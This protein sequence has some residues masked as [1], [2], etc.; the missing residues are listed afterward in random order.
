M[1]R[2][3]IDS[4]FNRIHGNSHSRRMLYMKQT[5]DPYPLKHSKHRKYCLFHMFSI[6]E[7]TTILQE[8]MEGRL[9]RIYNT[10]ISSLSNGRSR[11]R[12]RETRS[13]RHWR[14]L[15]SREEST[16]SEAGRWLLT[17][18][19]TNNK[20]KHNSAHKQTSDTQDISKKILST[21]LKKH[22]I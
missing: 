18:A 19:V 14:V 15:V 12:W 10:G 21:L 1:G 20:T 9:K 3:W 4:T 5:L 17:K 8:Q 16:M 13:N 11:A 7:M 2:K 22:Y 6:S